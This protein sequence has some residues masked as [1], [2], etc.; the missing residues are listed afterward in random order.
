MINARSEMVR[1]LPAFRDSIKLRGCLIPADGFYEWQRAGETKQ[2]FC[3]EV[4]DGKLFA[5]AGTWDRRKDPS[6]ANVETC[7][8]FTTTSNN[9]TATV[10]DRM[11]V[12]RDE[13]TYDLWLDPGMTRAEAACDLLKP[14]DYRLMHHFP[15]SSRANNV[16]TDDDACSSPAEISDLQAQLFA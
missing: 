15:V 2:P 9:L 12:I 7:S 14:Y 8:I 3:F 10:H 4:E 5:F 6:G 1:D 16:A 11:P 13:T